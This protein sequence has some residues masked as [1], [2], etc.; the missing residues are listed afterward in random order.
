MFQNILIGVIDLTFD[1]VF[2]NQ[3]SGYALD[4]NINFKIVFVN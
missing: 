4:C 3:N 1:Q 2:F